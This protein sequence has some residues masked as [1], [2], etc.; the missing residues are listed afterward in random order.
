MP[1]RRGTS[2]AKTSATTKP[3]AKKPRKGE[4]TVEGLAA[5]GAERLAA[6]VLE[7]AERDA[8]FKRV[9]KA[10]MAS[11]DGP[12]AVA[13]IIDRRLAALERARGFVDWDKVRGLA[14]D[15]AAM[16]AII[17]NQLAPLDPGSAAD[18]LVRFLLAR[19]P[20]SSAW[21]MVAADGFRRSMPAMR[22]LRSRRSR[23][24]FPPAMRT[25]W[26]NGWRVRRRMTA[27]AWSSARSRC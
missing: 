16:V 24:H 14:D 25:D 19:R 18:Q 15:L 27:T 10:A 26:R 8:S 12:D 22:W 2:A 5:L 23:R 9:A 11:A 13:A 20:C 4:L 1:R 17:R 21:T 3:A 6:L 7:A